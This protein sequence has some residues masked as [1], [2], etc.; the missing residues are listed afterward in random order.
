VST[1]KVMIIVLHVCR[2]K[3]TAGSRG[4]CA[5]VWVCELAWSASLRRR[6]RAT[7]GWG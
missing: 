2:P 6:W 5:A 4:V 3:T 7:Q 1:T